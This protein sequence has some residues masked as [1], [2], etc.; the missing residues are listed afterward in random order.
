MAMDL[1]IETQLSISQ[2]SLLYRMNILKKDDANNNND[3][4]GLILCSYQYIKLQTSMTV[5]K[6]ELYLNIKATN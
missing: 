4:Y 5:L 6:I 2:I 3:S 1:F